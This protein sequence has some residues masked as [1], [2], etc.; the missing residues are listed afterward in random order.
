V[1][2]LGVEY[3]GQSRSEKIADLRKAMQKADADTLVMTTLDDI[4]WLLN[5]RGNDV[6]CNPVVLSYLAATADALTLF[7]N[8]QVLSPEV[9]QALQSDGVTFAPYNDV[10][11]YVRNLTPGTTVMIDQEKAN[12]AILLAVPDGVAVVNETTPTQLPKGKKNPVEVANERLAH[13]KD[14][15]AVCKFMRWVKTNVGKIPMTEISAAERLEQFREEQEHYLGPSFDPIVSFGAHAAIVHYS[16]TPETD[17][18]LQP[19]S[20]LLADTGGQYLEGTTDI[21]RTFALG[22]VT[23]QQKYHFTLVLKGNLNLG[24][25]VFPAGASGANLDYIARKPLWD[26]HLDY[27]HGTGHGVGYLLNVHE[28]PQSISWQRAAAHTPLEVGMITSNEP[29]FYLEGEYGIRHE[30]LVVCVEDVKNDYAQFL[31]FDTLTM[32]PFDLDAVEPSLLTEHE[33]QLLN[34]YHQKVRDTIS[35][36]L[37]EEEAAWLANATRAI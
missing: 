30:N 17:I 35:P 33:R 7:I 14:G 10:Y 21:T 37:N 12:S 23:D 34:D 19:E 13:I 24:D 29:G 11:D 3:A 16:A 22:P 4:V 6:A 36:F 31:R 25:A 8:E 32:V 5:I 9:A 20:F 1:W 15:V 18:P 28:G 27:N 26:A 2:E